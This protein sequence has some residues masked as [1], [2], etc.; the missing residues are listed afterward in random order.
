MKDAIS[1]PSVGS[2]ALGV[3]LGRSRVSSPLP[4]FRVSFL[5]LMMILRFSALG[6]GRVAALGSRGATSRESRERGDQDHKYRLHTKGE[7]CN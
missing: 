5:C 4:S 6:E 2:A 7:V 1:V 3:V